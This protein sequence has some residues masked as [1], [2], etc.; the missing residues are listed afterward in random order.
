MNLLHFILD[1]NR[2]RAEA[3]R[4]E[5]EQRDRADDNPTTEQPE[6]AQPAI[7]AAPE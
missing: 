2:A 6:P 7:P 4:R 1:I 5:L 3:I